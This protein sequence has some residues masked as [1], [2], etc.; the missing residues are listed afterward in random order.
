MKKQEDRDWL[1]VQEGFD[2]SKNKHYEGAFCQGN[3]YFS[4]RASFEEGLSDA[5]QG[6]LYDRAFKSVTTEKQLNPK[7]KWGIYVPTIM[8]NHPNLNEV[9]INLPY[10]MS[11]KISFNGEVLDMEA[12]HIEAFKESLCLKDGTLTRTFKWHAKDGS[13]LKLCY[14]RYPSIY[15]KHLFIEDITVEV[16]VGEGEIYIQ[17]GIDGEVTTN[18]YNHFIQMKTYEQNECI[19]LK[20]KTDKQDEILQIAKV[21]SERDEWHTLKEENK[22]FQ[23]SK[24]HVVSGKSYTFQKRVLLLTSRDLESGR[25]EERAERLRE[26][27]SKSSREIYDAHRKL[28][29]E[30]WDISDVIIE[31]DREAQLAIRFSI[32]HLMRSNI[33]HDSRVAICA[34]GFAGEAYYGRYFWDT[35]IFILPFFIY[36]NPQAARNLLMYRYVTLDGARENAVKY[37]CKGA[38][39]PWQSGIRGDEQCSLWEYADNEIHITADIAYAIWHYYRATDDF[40]FIKDYGAEILVETARFWTDRVDQDREDGY[41]LIN[42]MGPDEYSAMTRNNSFTNRMVIFNLTK[43]IE[44]V[45]LIK[46]KDMDSYHKLRKKLKIEDKE[47][48]RFGEIA[49]KLPVCIDEETGIIQQ[50]EDFEDY[51]AIDMQS[52]WKDKSKPFGFFITQEKL[53]RSKCLKQADALTLAMLFKNEF[54]RAQIKDTYDYYEPMTTHDSSLSPV[55]HAIVAAWLD[56]KDHVDKFVKY[57]MALDFNPELKGAAEGIHIA[58]CGCL[59]QFIMTAVA[60]IET[61]IM[62]EKPVS[63]H[64]Y[65][66]NGWDEVSFKMIWRN[67]HHRITVLKDQIEISLI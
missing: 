33:E 19:A 37:H 13:L 34:K 62:E 16:I 6:E 60:G 53:Y 2:S 47:L 29:E 8:G 41:N 7:S 20:C 25:L 5:P 40:D 52:I 54:T 46:S 66:P 17:S 27:F 55:N 56:K 26:L 44:A 15:H 28:W 43:A 4:I 57:A 65:L 3:G 30:K 12:S 49:S 22:I 32:Y 10:F 21:F 67:Q 23:T 38:R 48:E 35:E 31:G 24:L 51:A 18:G 50:S 36:T 39:Y 59:W 63:V 64:T 14:F 9:I 58:N 1:I 42:V 45:E 61:A 11:F